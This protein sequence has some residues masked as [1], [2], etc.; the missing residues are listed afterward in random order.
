MYKGQDKDPHVKDHTIE[1]S[2]LVLMILFGIPLIS[3][4]AQSSTNH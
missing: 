2:P 3:S 1:T 4:I